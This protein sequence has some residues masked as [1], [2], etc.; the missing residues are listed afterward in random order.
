MVR[1]NGGSRHN[2]ILK[3]RARSS[4]TNCVRVMVRFRR[5][6]PGQAGTFSSP[7]RRVRPPLPPKP[8][9]Q[10]SRRVQTS[11]VRKGSALPNRFDS[12]ISAGRARLLSTRPGISLVS[13]A[14]RVSGTPVTRKMDNTR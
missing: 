5:S 10:R 14:L 3:S 4:E 9:G 11:P 8:L 7:A 1:P 6:R 12:L 13:V 2:A